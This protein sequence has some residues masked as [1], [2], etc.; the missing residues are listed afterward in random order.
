MNSSL[1][2]I[3][4]DVI[5]AEAEKLYETLEIPLEGHLKHGD[6]WFESFK[7]RHDIKVLTPHGQAGSVDE[8]AV[9]EYRQSLR[10]LLQQYESRNIWNLDEAGLYWRKNASTRTHTTQNSISGFKDSKQRITLVFCT[11]AAGTEKMP[12]GIINNSLKPTF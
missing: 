5:L 10:D 3:T 11:N 8:R 4:E 12:L 6:G 2:T 9:E 1:M 7:Q